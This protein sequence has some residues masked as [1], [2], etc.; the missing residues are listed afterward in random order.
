MIRINELHNLTSK[1]YIL[2]LTAGE[3]SIDNWQQILARFELELKEKVDSETDSDGRQDPSSRAHHSITGIKLIQSNATNR[4]TFQVP[5]CSAFPNLHS[6]MTFCVDFIKRL[7]TIEGTRI[8]YFA[9][10]LS[11][12]QAFLAY[13]SHQVEKDPPQNN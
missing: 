3:R 1:G 8:N 2:K 4:G 13:A 5:Q 12:E 10:K 6:A 11:L 9:A 7:H